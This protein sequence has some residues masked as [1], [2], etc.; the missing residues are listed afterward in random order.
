[1][2]TLG[3]DAPPELVSSPA[4]LPCWDDEA[5]A[6]LLVAIEQRFGVVLDAAVVRRA[7]RFADVADAVERGTGGRSVQVRRV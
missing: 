4:I 5:V 1:M 2:T 7:T 3:L 6:R